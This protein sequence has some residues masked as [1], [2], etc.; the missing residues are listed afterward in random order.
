MSATARVIDESMK[1]LGNFRVLQAQAI[2]LE[3]DPDQI[4]GALLLAMTTRESMGQNINNEAQTDKGCYQF[5]E[6]YHGDWLKKEPGC[7]EGTWRPVEGHSAFEDRFCPRFTPAT[8]RVVEVL[9]YNRQQA[10]ALNVEPENVVPFA[11]AAFNAG[12][13][14][15][16]E[17]WRAGDPDMKTTGGDYSKWVLGARSL[18]NSWLNRHPRWKLESL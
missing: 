14:G 12:V 2:A 17:G 10:F 5:T 16:T 1:N 13:G 9:R 7:P 3:G 15:A 18:V 11:V 6:R 4:S 8:I